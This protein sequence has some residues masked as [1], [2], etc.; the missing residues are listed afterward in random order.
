MYIHIPPIYRLYGTIQPTILTYIHTYIHTL[1]ICILLHT[2]D[3]SI[4]THTLDMYMSIL[5][6]LNGPKNVR[7]VLVGKN[8]NNLT[9][10]QAPIPLCTHGYLPS[11]TSTP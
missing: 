4:V 7:G 2:F 8:N 9:P 10:H 6:V 3:I 5:S 11:H 1:D